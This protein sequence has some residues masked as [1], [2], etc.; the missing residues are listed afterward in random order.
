MAKDLI[1]PGDPRFKLYYKDQ[2]DKIEEAERIEK[3]KQKAKEAEKAMLLH[4]NR[5]DINKRQQIKALLDIE[6]RIDG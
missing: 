2:Y 1:Q 3:Q 6:E 4:D 5:H